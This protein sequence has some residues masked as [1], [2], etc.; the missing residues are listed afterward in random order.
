M[1]CTYGCLW[2]RV[3]LPGDKLRVNP[4][5]ALGPLHIKVGGEGDAVVLVIDPQHLIDVN[6]EDI[7]HKIL[8]G[9]QK[10]FVEDNISKPNNFL[11]YL[12]ICCQTKVISPYMEF[13][14]SLT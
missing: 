13:K 8:V 14:Y 12:L 2:F 9:H 10:L 6:T 5:P 11:I 1:S 7:P 4:Q 3:V